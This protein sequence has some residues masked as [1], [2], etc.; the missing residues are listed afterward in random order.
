MIKLTYVPGYSNLNYYYGNPESGDEPGILN[1]FFARD[2]LT[3][4]ELPFPMRLSWRPEVSVTRAQL[5]KL[6]APAVVDALIEIQE[7]RGYD[8]LY[9]NG[10]DYYGGGFNFRLQR[11]G[12]KLSIHSWGAAIDV[13]PHLAPY[14]QRDDN[15][16]WINDQPAFIT[17]AFLSRGFFTYQ[18][19]GMHFQG[20]RST[21][22]EAVHFPSAFQGDT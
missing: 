12:R 3:I 13:N 15:G 19:D 20:V 1:K 9:E 7:H 16:R 10:F 2:Y 4:V 5:H 8:Y 6:V 18:Y 21:A 17:G 11:G 22:V 14:R